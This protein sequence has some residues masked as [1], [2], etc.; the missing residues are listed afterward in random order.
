MSYTQDNFKEWIFLIGEKMD[1]FTGDFARENNLNLDYSIHSLDEIE[2]WIITT[3]P[4][5]NQLKADHKML[6]LL[7]IYIGETFRKHLGGKWYM[8]TEDQENVYYMMPTLTSPEYSGEVYKSPRTFATASIP[9]KKGNYMS[10]IL[11]N[12]L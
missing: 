12:C 7:T 1:L 10:S 9:R 3:Y 8:N 2:K 4:T 6:D 11:R 5:I